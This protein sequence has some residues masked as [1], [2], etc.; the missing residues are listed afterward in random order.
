MQ[1]ILDTYFD[2]PEIQETIR[3]HADCVIYNPVREELSGDPSGT[4]F[5]FMSIYGMRKFSRRY[6]DFAHILS[7]G[8]KPTSF[9]Y[10]SYINDI[11]DYALNQKV[12]WM[13][14]GVLSKY[15][16]THAPAIFCR[17]DSG[18]KLWSGSVW[19]QGTSLAD[20]G[21]ESLSPSLMAVVGP[22]KKIQSEIRFHVAHGQIIAAARYAGD[23]LTPTDMDI[24]RDIIAAVNLPDPYTVV[25]MAKWDDKWYILELNCW[26]CSGIYDTAAVPNIIQAALK[27]Q[28]NIE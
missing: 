14:L 15:R 27:H 13:P 4:V 18:W 28:G 20:N 23:D 16:E 5:A 22:L 2:T 24:C 12:M 19:E 6:P 1:I 25:D 11:W 8:S 21:A 9:D 3:R 26:S 7:V 17:P 10:S